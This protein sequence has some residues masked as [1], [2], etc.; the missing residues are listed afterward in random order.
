MRLLGAAI[1]LTT[2]SVAA[3][4]PK[5]STTCA[6]DGFSA[7]P[8]LMELAGDPVV[9]YHADG[10]WTC[11]Y[12]TQK[13]GAGPGWFPSKNLRTVPFDPTPPLTAWVG[14]WAN[15]DDRIHIALSKTPG[16]LNLAGE[17][18]WR[19]RG[20]V[21]HSGEFAGEAS[22][23]GNHLHFVEEGAESC[24]IDLTLIG[25]YLVANDNDRC[26][27]ANVRFWGVWKRSEK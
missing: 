27:G 10:A 1:V 21:V 12:L 22:P 14:T 6:F 19:G 18:I 16:K 11:G 3:S 2:A 7:N 15:G 4:Q 20:D 24:I 8:Q 17:G 25:R 9:V 13:K 26:G 5:P 23:Q